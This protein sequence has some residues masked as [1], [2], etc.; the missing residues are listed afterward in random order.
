MVIP[1]TLEIALQTLA[2]YPGMHVLRSSNAR[3]FERRRNN[4][5]DPLRPHRFVSFCS[6]SLHK[7]KQNETVGVFPY[8][9]LLP[10]EIARFTPLSYQSSAEDCR[11]KAD[12]SKASSLWLFPPSP[13]IMA[14][15]GI[16]HDLWRKSSPTVS[17][18]K[19]CGGR[20]GVP[21]Y[22]DTGSSGARTFLPR[23]FVPT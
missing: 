1:L 6:A 15:G 4:E 10:V 12:S 7:S 21:H 11:L 5:A 20:W 19:M 9:A 3:A 2:A 8:L 23:R 13:R 18:A 17:S 16:R 22:R 14:K